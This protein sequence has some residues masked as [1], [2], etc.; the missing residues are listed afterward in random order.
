MFNSAGSG[1]YQ[2]SPTHVGNGDDH[3]PEGKQI[4]SVG[5]RKP[6][7]NRHENEARP[8][9]SRDRMATLGIDRFEEDD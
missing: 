7:P 8:P 1:V 6:K 9:T 4:D 5:P 3:S 2:L